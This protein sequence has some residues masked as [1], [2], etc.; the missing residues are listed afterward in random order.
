MAVTGALTRQTLGIAVLVANGILV[1]GGIGLGCTVVGRGDAV[2]GF[3]AIVAV[4]VVHSAVRVFI[5]RDKNF[6]ILE[7]SLFCTAQRRKIRNVLHLI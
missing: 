7:V 2:T 1:Y 4:P 6:I 5:C 3:T